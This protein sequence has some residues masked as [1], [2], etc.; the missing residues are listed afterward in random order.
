MS[1]EERKHIYGYIDGIIA[2]L[3]IIKSSIDE[4]DG[5]YGVE[6]NLLDTLAEDTTNV[7]QYLVSLKNDSEF[8]KQIMK[9]TNATNDERKDFVK[10]YLREERLKSII[11]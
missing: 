5:N 3:V 2:H 9:M 6:V 7:I 4:F 1:P 11:K 8:E 10:Q